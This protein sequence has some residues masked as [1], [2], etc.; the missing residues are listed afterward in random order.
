MIS[1]NE[2]RLARDLFAVN[3]RLSVIC[4]GHKIDDASN[5]VAPAILSQAFRRRCASWPPTCASS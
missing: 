5:P 1:K 2:S 4:G 3:Q